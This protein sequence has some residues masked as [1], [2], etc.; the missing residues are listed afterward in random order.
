MNCPASSID[1]KGRPWGYQTLSGQNHT[2]AAGGAVS[3]F[4]PTRRPTGWRQR[5]TTNRSD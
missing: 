5:R 4:L 2:P 3:F 1:S